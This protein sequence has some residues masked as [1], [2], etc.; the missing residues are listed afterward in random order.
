MSVAGGIP[1]MER[2]SSARDGADGQYTVRPYESGD[3][4]DVLALYE[5]VWGSEHDAGWLA[6]KYEANPYVDGTAT[7]VAE[8][9]GTVV[10]ARPAIPLPMRVGDSSLHGCFLV[11]LMV[12]PDHRRRGLFT[13]MMA[14]GLDH[15]ADAGVSI[16]F[17]YGNELSAPGYRKLGFDRLGEGPGSRLRVQRPGRFVADR[18]PAP[19][20]RAV[21]A[22]AD[23]AAGGYFA[24]RDGLAFGDDDDGPDDLSVERR[25]GLAA[26]LL[27]GLYERAPPP[28]GLHTRRELAFYDWLAANPGWSHE[29]YVARERGTPVAAL[30]VKRRPDGSEALRIVDAVPATTPETRPAFAALLRALLA[31]EDTAPS[32]STSGLVHWEQVLPD[33]LLAR[34]GFRSDGRLPLSRLTAPDDTVLT[35]LVD[36][37]ASRVRAAEGVDLR[38]GSNWR[39]RLR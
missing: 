8:T 39:L 5:T 33:D 6:Y 24:V 7:M 37:A 9:D 32:I 14:R 23:A 36:D 2:S 30:L 34:F 16:C 18:V 15:Y 31:V 38:D 22:A 13:R 35:Y 28:P 21:A 11:S 27:V 26:D 17:N 1:T 4:A 10:G 3:A 12:H 29:T 19:A 20:G 25:D